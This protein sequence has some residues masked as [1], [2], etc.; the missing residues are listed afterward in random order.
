MRKALLNVLIDR[1]GRAL[2]NF[3]IL[4]AQPT[5]EC[6]NALEYVDAMFMTTV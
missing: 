5:K 1:R 3:G 6:G 4:L 2:T